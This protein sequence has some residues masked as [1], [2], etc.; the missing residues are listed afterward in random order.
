VHA[1]RSGVFL[2]PD[3]DDYTDHLGGTAGLLVALGWVLLAALVLWSQRQRLFALP[4]ACQGEETR[5]TLARRM[6]LW[7][8]SDPLYPGV[9]VIDGWR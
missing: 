5:V 2:P 1:Y 8:L 3:L 7:G 9:M 6:Q 4:R